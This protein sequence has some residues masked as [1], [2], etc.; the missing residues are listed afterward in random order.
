MTEQVFS[1]IAAYGRPMT[2]VDDTGGETPCR[3]FL[4]PVDP[5]DYDG[6]AL[7]QAPGTA[8]KVEYLLLLPPEAVTPGRT[9]ETVLCGGAAYE[10]LA[11]QGIFCGETLTH[12][13]G[14]ARK[15]GGGT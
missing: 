1:R 12:W 14:A 9:A 10:V 5:M 7:F 15:K 3:G 6:V 13:E 8:S 11:V 4:Q 2:V